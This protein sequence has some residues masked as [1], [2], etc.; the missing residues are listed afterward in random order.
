MSNVC[1]FHFFSD[2][3]IAFRSKA[4]KHCSWQFYLVWADNGQNLFITTKTDSK[5]DPSLSFFWQIANVLMIPNFGLSLAHQPNTTVSKQSKPLITVLMSTADLF[6]SWIIFRCSKQGNKRWRRVRKLSV[7]YKRKRRDWCRLWI[8]R[9]DKTKNLQERLFLRRFH[10]YGT[11]VI[12]H[13]P[14]FYLGQNTNVI[15]QLKYK[16]LQKARVS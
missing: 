10:R 7:N 3:K 6:I 11:A 12:D 13:F 5:V 14:H 16:I 1:H 8:F 9:H 15:S 2:H 4:A